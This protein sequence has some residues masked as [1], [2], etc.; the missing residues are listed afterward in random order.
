MGATTGMAEDALP[1]P[2]IQDLLFLFITIIFIIY[3]MLYII[4]I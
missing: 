2:G 4:Y 3:I 1:P